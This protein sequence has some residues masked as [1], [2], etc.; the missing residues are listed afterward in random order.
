MDPALRTLAEEYR[1]DSADTADASQQLRSLQEQYQR[2][3]EASL[4]DAT[5]AA[6]ALTSVHLLR[7]AELSPQMEEA[8]RL[9]Y[10]NVD[11]A[12]LSG[13]SPEELAGFVNA[14]KGKYFEVLVRDELNAGEVVGDVF[15][16]SG[17]Y[18]ELAESAVQPGWDLQIFDADGTVADYLQLKATSDLSYVKRALETY[19]D[20]RV[21]ATDEVAAL[22][23]EILSSGIANADLIEGMLE[24]ME[25]LAASP[26]AD[27]AGD[28][29]PFLPVLVLAVS[30]GRFVITG[31]KSLRD[32]VADGADRAVKTG[33]AMAV[34]SAVM[35][36]DGGLLSVPAAILTRAGIDRYQ[37]M[38]RV[39]RRLDAEERSVRE[40]LRVYGSPPLEVLPAATLTA[41][42]N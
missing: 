30:E 12:S 27:L 7:P 10:P 38:R 25:A 5:A 16:A 40:L 13:R 14:W 39:V 34:G 32:A 42:S 21:L 9:A 19:P 37:L 33:A 36:L 26:L 6:A 1:R 11:L 3:S 4:L 41:G 35:W 18:A 28:V 22:S 23:E 29:L 31:R 20:I 24:P 15:L 17:Q 2:Q 8:F